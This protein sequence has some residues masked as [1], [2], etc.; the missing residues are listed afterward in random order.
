MSH[1][2]VCLR[3]VILVI[4]DELL[5]RDEFISSLVDMSLLV[6][7]RL[8]LWLHELFNKGLGTI[9]QFVLETC[10]YNVLSLFNVVKLLYGLHPVSCS[11]GGLSVSWCTTR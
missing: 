6:D 4:R 3:S 5:L 9:V 1:S 8:D 7:Q 10:D 2:K 11:R